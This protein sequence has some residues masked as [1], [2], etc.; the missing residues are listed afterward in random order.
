MIMLPV[1]LS[2]IAAHD[3]SSPSFADFPVCLLLSICY[4]CSIGGIGT[5]IGTG[6]NMFFAAYMDGELLRPMGFAQWMGIA[7]PVVVIFLPVAWF[8]LT[9]VIFRIP[10][11][12]GSLTADDKPTAK[13]EPWNRGAVM[14]LVVFISCAL[15][16][17]LIPVIRQWPPLEDPGPTSHK[18]PPPPVDSRQMKL[19]SGVPLV[20]PWAPV[21]EPPTA[22]P[23]VPPPPAPPPPEPPLPCTH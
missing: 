2:V 20:A 5:L 4:A 13:I 1:A 10:A 21:P 18:Q 8:L 15:G 7:L 17:M 19:S 11:Q 16:W 23:P 9:R 12:S 22:P 3:T 14:T 6:T